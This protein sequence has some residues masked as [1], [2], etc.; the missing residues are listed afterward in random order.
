MKLT[1]QLGGRYGV[2]C[3]KAI[4]S[5]W[6]VTYLASLSAEKRSAGQ[7]FKWE[8]QKN[9]YQPVAWYPFAR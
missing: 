5:I 6:K 3:T 1:L 8:A 7:Y 2:H 4:A 9:K